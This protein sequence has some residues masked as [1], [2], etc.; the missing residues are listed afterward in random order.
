MITLHGHWYF[1]LDNTFLFNILTLVMKWN[2]DRPHR[3]FKNTM[4]CFVFLY[5]YNTAGHF[6]QMEI[7]HLDLLT[8]Q[9]PTRD[10]YI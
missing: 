1:N 10:K 7:S 9:R 3:S 2:T 6:Q 5:I 4:R 8:N